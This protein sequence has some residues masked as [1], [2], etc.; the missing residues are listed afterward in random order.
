MWLPVIMWLSRELLGLVIP[1]VQQY[2]AV[3]DSKRNQVGVN[4]RQSETG[5]EL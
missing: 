1:V 3:A 2:C 4:R 5:L